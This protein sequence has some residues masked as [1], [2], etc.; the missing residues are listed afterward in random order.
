MEI[1]H[2]ILN[3]DSYKGKNDITINTPLSDQ[4]SHC[5]VV[6]KS[7]ELT[8]QNWPE[9]GPKSARNWP[10]IGPKL[11]RNWPN[12]KYFSPKLTRGTLPVARARPGPKPQARNPTRTM[13]QVA[14][15]SPTF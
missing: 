4:S 8:A 3:R 12:L 14:R 13:K 6:K 2:L 7:S 15:P 9:F 10:E 11:A 1:C 5:S